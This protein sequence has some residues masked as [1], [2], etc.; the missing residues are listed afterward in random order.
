MSNSE[1]LNSVSISDDRIMETSDA[2]I[3]L[4]DVAGPGTPLVMIHANSVSKETFR[5]QFGALG[6]MRRAIALDLPGHGASAN[7]TDAQ[8]SYTILATRTPRLKFCGNR[9]SPILLPSVTH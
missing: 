3:A 7:A 2:P 1:I 4:L 8:R 6:D 9:V 5:L